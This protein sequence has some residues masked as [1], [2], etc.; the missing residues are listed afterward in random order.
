MIQD[1]DIPLSRAAEFLEFFHAEVGILPVWICPIAAPSAAARFP[2]YPL[3][4]RT[5]Y[6]N[7]GFWDVVRAR[8]PRAAGYVNRKIERKVAELGGIKSLY[9][10]SYYPRAEFWSTFD[11]EAYAALKARYDPTGTLGD[12]YDKCVLR[13]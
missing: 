12:L 2:L 3:A 1:V 9:S 4:P 10:D 6:I 13:R 8:A 5:P 11:G 7:F